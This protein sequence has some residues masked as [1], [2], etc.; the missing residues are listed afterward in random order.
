MFRHQFSLLVVGPTQSGKTH[1]VKQILTSDR[2]LY[3]AKKP[4]RVSWYYSQ[5]QDGYEALKT[6]FRKEI[7]CFCGLPNFHEDLREIDPKYNKLLIFDDLTSEVIQSPIVSRLFTQ[8]R[9]RNASVILL[10]QNMFPKRKFNTNISRNAQYMALFHSPGDQNEIGIIAERTFDKKRQ[11]FM[12]AYFGKT[13]K[14]YD[15]IFV[16]NRL[17]LLSSLPDYQQILETRGKGRNEP[18]KG[19]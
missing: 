16:D 4:R 18:S 7:Q 1:F 10:L 3:E 8:G 13:E 6:K 2:I 17:W 9:H 12:A 11:R 19:S 5:W 14:P 15:Y